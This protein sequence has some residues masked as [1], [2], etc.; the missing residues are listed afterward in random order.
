MEGLRSDDEPD[1]ISIR[2]ISRSLFQINSNN[3]RVVGRLDEFSDG[4]TDNGTT[5]VQQQPSIVAR[6]QQLGICVFQYSDTAR[7]TISFI[8]KGAGR[9]GRQVCVALFRVSGE[10][11]ES[12]EST[13]EVMEERDY[14]T[15][16]T[17]TL[18]VEDAGAVLWVAVFEDDEE[19]AAF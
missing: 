9:K 6:T 7:E 19:A 1:L 16:L 14:E 5:L 3:E 17:A 11:R 13:L 2:P 10:E 12:A 15:V 8:L 4:V 18:S